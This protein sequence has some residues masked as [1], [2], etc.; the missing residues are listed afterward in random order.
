MELPLGLVQVA[1]P[2][3]EIA[4]PEMEPGDLLARHPVAAVSLRRGLPEQAASL[5]R[6]AAQLL[7]VRQPRCHAQLALV[8]GQAAEQLA[9]SS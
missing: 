3:R 5:V 7:P 1:G 6:T 8:G 9:A 2:Q 4:E